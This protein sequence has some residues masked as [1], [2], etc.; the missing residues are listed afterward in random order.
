MSY[1]D[2]LLHPLTDFVS[3]ADIEE[4][5]I[6]TY[7]YQGICPKTEV[8]LKLPRTI[9]AEKIALSLCRQLKEANFSTVK[10]KMLGI[11]IVKNSQEK[12][13]VIKAFSGLLNGKKEVNGWVSQIS[14]NSVIALAENFTLKQLDEIKNEI[15][16]LENLIIREEYKQLKIEY[17]N[18]WRELKAIHH[19]RKEIR[20]KKRILYTDTFNNSYLVIAIASIFLLTFSL[21]NNQTRFSYGLLLEFDINKKLYNL[22]QESRKDD[23]QRR[24]LKHQWQ[25]KIKPLEE[26]INQANLK[27]KQLKQQRKELSKQLQAQMQTAYTITNFMGDSLSIGK[28]LDK[29]F[30]PTGTGDCCTPK[31][32]HYAA[33]NNLQPLAMAEVWWGENSPN[34]EKIEGY[35]YPACEER[36]QPL[37]GFLL[38]G[39]P[40]VEAIDTQES[41]PI[42][43]EDEWL[44]VVNK[45]SGLLSVSGRG[46]KNFDSVLIRFKQIFRDNR[47]YDIT[48][49][50]RLDQD[51][52]G[53]L[54]LAKTK[55]SYLHLSQ[56][57][58]QRQVKKVYEAV[59]DGLISSSQGII[60]LP[61]WSNPLTR[62]RQEVNYDDGKPS[63]T[64]FQVM[65][66]ENEETRLQLKPI[67]GRTHQLR[68]HCAEGLGVAIKGD[69]FYGKSKDNSLR[70]HLHAREI[71]FI[72]PQQ[73]KMIHLQAPTP[74]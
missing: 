64:H 57:F 2:K 22:Q 25:E 65:G 33:T 12:L 61:L 69:H 66:I 9:L 47:N 36:C 23:W 10:G 63:V 5:E 8:N 53:I 1:L 54:I 67:T 7:Y 40:R 43:Y 44:L 41:I 11:L 17:E 16:A 58:A 28:L 15:L 68:V 51:T 60:N 19:Q 52:S 71:K 73:Q 38:S 42:I 62:P 56:Q 18:Q 31:L 27:I 21:N 32:L 29:T 45:P 24:N 72:H 30:I 46:S 48:T 13:G 4:K 14:S 26:V 39:L 3:S 49:V 37:M 70:L 55:E 34:G 59:T 35:F 74:F 20:D 6:I 50:H